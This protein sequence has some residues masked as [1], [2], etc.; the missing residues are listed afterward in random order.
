MTQA[1]AS[2]TISLA[3]CSTSYAALLALGVPAF[4]YL[5]GGMV[6]MSLM[7]E[8]GEQILQFRMK[9]AAFVETTKSTVDFTQKNL[10][11][12]LSDLGIM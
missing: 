5:G 11:G 4:K 2:S 3:D 10:A 12:I 9:T 6:L 8:T 7:S 1:T